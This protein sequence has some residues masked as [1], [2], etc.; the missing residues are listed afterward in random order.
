MQNE[1]LDPVSSSLGCYPEEDELEDEEGLDPSK[2]LFS[3]TSSRR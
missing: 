2:H 1:Q 3:G